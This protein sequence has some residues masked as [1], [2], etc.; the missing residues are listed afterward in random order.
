MITLTEVSTDPGCSAQCCTSEEKA[1][2]PND[3]TARQQ[4][5]GTKGRS[6]QPRL[7]KQFPWLTVCVS[8]VKVF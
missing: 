3:K 2:Q 5:L 6:F 8:E 7:Y 1:F 4:L